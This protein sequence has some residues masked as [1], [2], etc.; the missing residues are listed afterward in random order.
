MAAA[1]LA[2]VNEALVAPL[3]FPVLIMSVPLNCHWKVGEGL[4]LAAAVKEAE[5]PAVTVWLAGCVVMA[6]AAGAAETVR[7]APLLVAEP[8]ELVAT[9]V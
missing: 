2:M 1:T 9:T 6:G 4:P 5:G 8:A 7:T 3:I